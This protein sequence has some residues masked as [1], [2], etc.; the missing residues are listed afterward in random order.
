ML[1]V[2]NLRREERG[3]PL[4]ELGDNKA[5]QQHAEALLANCAS[6]HWGPDGMKPYMRY[7]LAGGTQSSAENVNGLNR[8]TD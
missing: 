3:L 5:A 2:I 4:V 6:S 1:G 7:T 8:T